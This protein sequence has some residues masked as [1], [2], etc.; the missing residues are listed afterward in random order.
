MLQTHSF[1]FTGNGKENAFSSS[2][3]VS[4]LEC[5]KNHNSY[6]PFLDQRFCNQYHDKVLTDFWLSSFRER[7]IGL[8]SYTSKLKKN[9]QNN[10]K[11]DSNIH[12]LKVH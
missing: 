2:K 1:N 4:L 11:C 8:Q 10:V 7:Y 5:T 3:K 6:L 9:E 12:Y